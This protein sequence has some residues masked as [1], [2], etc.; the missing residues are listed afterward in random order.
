MNR[1][2]RERRGYVPDDRPGR[3]LFVAVPLPPPARA[4]VQAL[5]DEVRSAAD[6]AIRDVRW[7]RL[8]GLHLTLRFLGPTVEEQVPGVLAAADAAA[9][10]HDP[11]AVELRGAGA[12]PSAVRP[13]ALWLGIDGGSEGLGALAAT[14]DEELARHG[15]P[16]S[17]RPYRAHLTLARADGVRSGPAVA[18]RL[19][20]AAGRFLEHF[21]AGSVGV[22]ETISGNGPA[23]Y[24]AVHEARLGAPVGAPRRV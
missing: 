11:F 7:V 6:P 23:R 9:A 8:D 15:W 5:V 13:R 14:V 10:R 24:E 20:T 3:R 2:G 22:F 21:E 19:M 12:F 4:T 16:P 18:A 17:E 1:A